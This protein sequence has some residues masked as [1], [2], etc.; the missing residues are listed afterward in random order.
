MKINVLDC[1]L[2]DGG[3]CNNWMFGRDNV[4][5]IISGLIAANVEF[6]ECGFLTNRVEFDTNRTKFSTVDQ[7]TDLIPK[8][9]GSKPCLVMINYGEYES[10]DLPECS[11]TSIDGIRVAFHKKDLFNA[12]KFCEDIKKKGYMVFVQPMVSMSYSEKEFVTL[13]HEVNHLKPYAFYIVDSFGMMK[14]KALMKLVELTEMN[15]LD[16]I[17][18]GFHAHN[19]LQ[20]AYSNAQYFAELPLKRSVVIDVSVHGMGRGAGNLNAELFLEYLNETV[21]ACYSVKSILNLMDEIV[22]RFYE[23]RPWGYSLPNYL[24]ASHMIHPN[25]ATYLDDKKT[26]TLQAMDEIFSLMDAEK[27]LE[28]DEKYIEQLYI[29]YLSKR[30]IE[31]SSIKELAERIKDNKILLIAPGKSV[32]D[33]KEKIIEFVKNENPI[34]FSINHDYPYIQ[35]DYIFVSNMRRFRQLSSM[36]YDKTIITSNINSRKTYACVDYFKLL[37]DIEG[38]RDNAGLMAIKFIADMAAVEFFLAGFDGYSHDIY[39][40]F[41]TKDMALINSPDYLDRMNAGMRRCL[42]MFSDDL[43]IS[44]LTESKVDPNIE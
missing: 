38:V 35:S 39:S 18:L 31:K 27:G 17:L 24:S 6:I 32:V 30:E 14:R 23:E 7:I 15:L 2:R 25:Y 8:G 20:L 21:N 12:L 29:N 41:E 36:V 22:S 3:Y 26:L 43:K 4:R 44:F 28:Y 11:E 16:D 5:Q 40:N 9:N 33:Q 34:I 10:K 13:I 42:K 37:N 1:T 19:N